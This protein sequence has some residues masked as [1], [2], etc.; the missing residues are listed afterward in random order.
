MYSYII[1]KVSEI[2]SNNIVLECNNIGY[3][4]YVA[5][6]FSYSVGEEY[7]VYVYNKISEDE[8]SLYGF[9]TKEEYE[10]FLKL[11]SVKGL[12]AKLA[13]PI[14]ATGSISGIVDAINRENILYLTNLFQE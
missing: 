14:L 10:L 8:Y 13:L 4:I 5:N 2:N 12:G 3:L 1:G 9:K 6:P 11:I 7:K